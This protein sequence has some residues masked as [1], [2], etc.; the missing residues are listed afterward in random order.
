M[1]S[2]KGLQESGYLRGLSEAGMGGFRERGV[3]LP[4]F[5]GSWD[6]LEQDHG[7]FFQFCSIVWTART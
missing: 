7:N 4:C 3:W 1:D 5:L 2:A 6:I